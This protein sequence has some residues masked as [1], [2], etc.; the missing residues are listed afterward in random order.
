MTNNKP[1]Q[2]LLPDPM[3]KPI[4]V[5]L[6]DL[7]LSVQAQPPADE[8]VTWVSRGGISPITI[9]PLEHGKK[10]YVIDGRCR[11]LA[12]LKLEEQG[13][14]FPDNVKPMDLEIPAQLR[15]DLR[16]GHAETS[17]LAIVINKVRSDNPTTDRHA[18][19]MAISAL[20]VD[21]HT[22]EGKQQL[23]NYLSIGHSKLVKL[24]KYIDLPDP[25]FNAFQQGDV[26]K[27]TIDALVKLRG[28]DS[29]AAAS[30]VERIEAGEK[31]SAAAVSE[32]GKQVSMAILD[33]LDLGN[34]TYAK[35]SSPLEDAIVLLKSLVDGKGNITKAALKEVIE[36]L[37]QLL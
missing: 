13:F 18:I 29:R 36:M 31:V 34:M 35:M 6:K 4:K 28:K 32:A 24:L 21:P 15:E 1:P 7:D 33:T 3:A 30:I 26:S 8:L 11:V 2:P 16:P 23:S 9:C 37:E 5:T 17:R 12:L 27:Q 10:Y 19:L 20:G 25:V 14:L 22:K